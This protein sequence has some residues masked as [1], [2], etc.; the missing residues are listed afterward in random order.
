MSPKPPGIKTG[1]SYCDRCGLPRRSYACTERSEKAWDARECWVPEG[2]LL[3]EH[4]VDTGFFRILD[5]KSISAS[6]A[7]QAEEDKNIF[8]AIERAMVPE[9]SVWIRQ[10]KPA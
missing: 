2:T 10:E 3:V 5:R 9:G 8:E 1:E 7:I 6:E 4:E